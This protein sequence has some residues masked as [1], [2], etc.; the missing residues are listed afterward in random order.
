MKTFNDLSDWRSVRR[1]IKGSIGFVP[2]MG[3]LHAG[4]ESLIEQSVKENDF[5]VLSIFVN[6]TQ[7]NNPKDLET[8][9]DRLEEDLDKARRLGVD[10]VIL[11]DYES[12]Y[13]DGFRYQVEE[14]NLSKKL[15]GAHRPGHFTGVLTV[16][17]KLLNL[18]RAD[19]A[20]FGEKDYQQYQLIKG[21][22]EAF[23]M[24]TEII[25]CPTVREAD[26]LAMSSRNLNLDARG[27]VK[28]VSISQWI[29]D[30]ISDKEL[31]RRLTD[32]GF[33]VD[34]VETIEG[35]RYVAASLTCGEGENQKV[36]RLIDNADVENPSTN[37]LNIENDLIGEATG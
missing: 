32:E 15:C 22:K 6:P 10:A 36:V 31:A 20:Y 13:A 12:L 2:T 26:G 9:P 1:G 5:T 35:R 4:H 27:R 30:A 17:M 16:V 34:Y 18:V 8:Y 28:A 14:N 19:R 7:F 11:P 21:M 25:G 3:A 37:K 23:F 33:A 29:G 24:E